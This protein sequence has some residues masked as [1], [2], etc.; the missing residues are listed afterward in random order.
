[1]KVHKL[2]SDQSG[3]TLVE[4][5]GGLVVLVIVLLLIYSGFVFA[6][7]VFGQGD[8]WQNQTQGNF[9]ELEKGGSS[10]KEKA[11]VPLK[12]GDKTLKINGTYLHTGQNATGLVAFE[13]E[14][15]SR[16][17]EGVRDNFLYWY[18]KFKLMTERER[19]AAG[20]PRF[21]TNDLVRNWIITNQFDGAWPVLSEDFL[22]RN[23][24]PT[25]KVMY[26]QPY[27]YADTEDVFV[28][29]VNSLGGNWYTGLVYDFEDRAW[30]HAKANN[31][32]SINQSW[33]IVKAIIHSD[34][35]VKMR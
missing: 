26:I 19:L 32:V 24:Y 21:L 8:A 27:F 4:T 11:E 9:A 31:M 23:G 25:D 7:K 3:M 6:A 14:S 35:W 33:E 1:M 34:T 13:V 28:F 2:R 12:F 16:I 5:I 17:P 29:A 20:Y 15:V 22:K 18:D 10:A 30:Y